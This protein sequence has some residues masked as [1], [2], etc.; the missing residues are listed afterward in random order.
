ML[1]QM[2]MHRLKNVPS[3][4][5]GA[6]CVEQVGIELF[7][8]SPYLYQLSAGT[9]TVCNSLFVCL[10]K[11]ALL[12]HYVQS[13]LQPPL[14]RHYSFGVLLHEWTWTCKIHKF[15]NSFSVVSYFEHVYMFPFMWLLVE[16][17][18]EVLHM[19]LCTYGF[20]SHILEVADTCPVALG[21]KQSPLSLGL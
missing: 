10:F 18:L 5:F 13:F 17:P 19:Y 21:T 3:C 11:L 20:T 14:K 8:D 6:C 7:N 4:L 9:A 12:I 2:T 16:T 15:T 1:L